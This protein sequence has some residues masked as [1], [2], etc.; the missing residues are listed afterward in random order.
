MNLASKYKEY[1]RLRDSLKGERP[2]CASPRA[3]KRQRVDQPIIDPSRTPSKPLSKPIATPSRTRRPHSDE[4]QAIAQSPEATPRQLY[5]TFVG[6]TPQKDGIPLG[7]FEFLSPHQ[8]SPSIKRNPDRPALSTLS[9]NIPTTPSKRPHNTF[10]HDD[11]P[12]TAS[13]SRF[14]RTPTSTGKRF[15]LDTIVTPPRHARNTEGHATPSSSTKHMQ[16][17]T[18]LR[19]DSTR[20][21]I[22]VEENEAHDGGKEAAAEPLFKKRRGFG[23]SLSAIIRGLRRK[24]DDEFADEMEIQREMEMELETGQSKSQTNRNHN[25]GS[26]EGEKVLVEDSQVVMPLGPEGYGS[27]EGDEKDN[28]ESKP[29]TQPWK[30]WKKKGMKRQTKRINIRPVA[31]KPTPQVLPL[32]LEDDEDASPAIIPESQTNES[33]ERGGAEDDPDWDPV[34]KNVE[35]ASSESGAFLSG[36]LAKSSKPPVPA[37]DSQGTQPKSQKPKRKVNPQA[38]A[39]YRRL[40]I[41]SKNGNGQGRGR[42]GRGRK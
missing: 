35:A 29:S 30:P 24:E 26:G 33:L 37:T 41:K 10:F 17:P 11:A 42:F 15:L 25:L 32:L 5:P 21:N 34:E 14:T 22:L 23:R 40:K 7:L 12:D 2:I 3:A 38:H 1:D 4:N 8:C 20:L 13:H 28:P 27:D 6:P 16:T 31:S 9:G 39:N 18:F 19:R 36:A